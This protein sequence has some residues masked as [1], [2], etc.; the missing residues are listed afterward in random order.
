MANFGST[1]VLSGIQV[2]DS[3][4]QPVSNFNVTAA[5]GTSYPI[6]VPEPAAFVMFTLGAIAVILRFLKRCLAA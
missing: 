3:N 5:S 6:A 4:H 1:A 2:F